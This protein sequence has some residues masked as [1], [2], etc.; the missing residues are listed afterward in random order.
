MSSEEPSHDQT[1]VKYLSIVS[2]TRS[3]DQNTRNFSN[4]LQTSGLEEIPEIIPARCQNSLKMVSD[5]KLKDS[6]HTRPD[7]RLVHRKKVAEQARLYSSHISN[8]IQVSRSTYPH[9]SAHETSAN[10]S[11]MIGPGVVNFSVGPDEIHFA[12][13]KHLLCDRVPYFQS[14]LHESSFKGSISNPAVFPEDDVEA[15]DILLTC[16]YSGKVRAVECTIADGRISQEVQTVIET[17]QTS[18]AP[19]API[20]LITWSP[21][22]A[23]SLAEKLCL[24]ELMDRIM[25]RFRLA[26]QGRIITVTPQLFRQVYTVFPLPNK[27]RDYVT[28]LFRWAFESP[29]YEVRT[30]CPAT[31]LA[32]LQNDFP[33]LSFALFK[34]RRAEPTTLRLGHMKKCFFHCHEDGECYLL[35]DGKRGHRNATG[36]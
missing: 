19:G 16:V 34:L 18:A 1:V 12:V 13:H 10:Y 3:R 26:I 35:K 15:F 14:M 17:A 29:A 25:D 32:A 27:L 5:W 9:L 33:E 30:L 2:P 8:F 24:P 22:S 6:Q 31:Q 4:I 11:R 21:I 23:Y 20:P 7:A 28:R 36:S